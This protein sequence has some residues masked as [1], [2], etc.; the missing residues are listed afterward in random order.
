[1]TALDGLEFGTQF[2]P[3]TVPGLAALQIPL[4]VMATDLHRRAEAP[5]SPWAHYGSLSLIPKSRQA[6]A[7][8]ARRN[9][10]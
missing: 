7:R 10:P 5:L 6:G 1:M 3:D 4:T 9:V 8:T 2:L